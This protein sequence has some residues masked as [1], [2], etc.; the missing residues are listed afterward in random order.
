[1]LTVLMTHLIAVAFST[2]CFCTCFYVICK[3]STLQLQALLV[4]VACAALGLLVLPAGGSIKLY[5]PKQL[6]PTGAVWAFP[7]CHWLF[8][9][10]LA[11]KLSKAACITAHVG[12]VILQCLATLILQ[13]L[14]ASMCAH[15][16]RHVQ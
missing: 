9:L 7:W 8:E 6:T 10:C 4:A 1:M 15:H 13:F 5:F 2:D 14:T 11:G 12:C 3:I 16:A